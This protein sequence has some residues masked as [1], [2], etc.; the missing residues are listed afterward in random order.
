MRH[1]DPIVTDILQR[2]YRPGWSW[3]VL[4]NCTYFFMLAGSKAIH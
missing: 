1:Y 2:N 4:P 3:M